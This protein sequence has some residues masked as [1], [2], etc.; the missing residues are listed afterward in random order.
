MSKL[1]PHPWKCFTDKLVLQ[2]EARVRRLPRYNINCSL[3]LRMSGP[4]SRDRQLDGTR[5]YEIDTGHD[6]MITQPRAVADMLLE[7]AADV[8]L[9]A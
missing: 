5:N 8:P 1:T 4:A 7:I 6:L 9:P 2:D 3:P